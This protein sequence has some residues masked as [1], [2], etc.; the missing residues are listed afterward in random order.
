M[1]TQRAILVKSI[2]FLFALLPYSSDFNFNEHKHRPKD[3]V[4]QSFIDHVF[5]PVNDMRIENGA[6]SLKHTDGLIETFQLSDFT[7]L[8][9][10]RCKMGADIHPSEDFKVFRGFKLFSERLK[11]SH[12]KRS[13]KA[14]SYQVMLASNGFGLSD[15][16]VHA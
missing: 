7:K 2:F 5:T 11:I 16:M 6:L 3:G 13:S 10:S 15:C 1:L 8:V 4:I 14:F 12:Y 9:L